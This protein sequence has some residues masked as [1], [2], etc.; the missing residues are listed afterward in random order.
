LRADPAVRSELVHDGDIAGRVSRVGGLRVSGIEPV[1]ELMDGRGHIRS[2]GRH[3][4]YG[5]K[6]ELQGEN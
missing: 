3:R 6:G 5:N 4:G 2:R 1:D